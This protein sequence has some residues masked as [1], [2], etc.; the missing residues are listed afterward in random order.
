MSPPPS[1]PEAVPRGSKPTTVAG[2]SGAST[3]PE[4]SQSDVGESLPE[5]VVE[6]ARQYRQNFC[7]P[8]GFHLSADVYVLELER[9]WR[10]SWLFACHSAELRGTG[11][12]AVFGLGDDSVVLVRGGDG[13]ARAFHNVCRHRGSRLVDAPRDAASPITS[14]PP[15]GAGPQAPAR[16]TARQRPASR[17][18]CPYHQWSYQLD[19]TL[20]GCGGMDRVEDLDPSQFGLWPVQCMEVE[21][22]VFIRLAPPAAHLQTRPSGSAVAGLGVDPARPLDLARELADALAS[23]G[24][25]RAKVAHQERYEVGAGW[26][27]VWENN[28]ECWHCH[29][30][31][32]EYN[33]SH[34]DIADTSLSAV[35]HEIAE[36]TRAMVAALDVVGCSHGRGGGEVFADGGL[37]PFPSPERSWSAHRTPLARGYLTESAD[38]GALAPL[39]GAYRSHDVG[40]LRLRAL[41]NFWCHASADYAVTT[42]LA[43]ID[44]GRTEVLVTWLVNEEAEEGKDYELERLLAVWARTSEQDWA[45]CQRAQLGLRSSAYVPGPLSSRYEA[46]VSAFH[47]WYLRALGLMDGPGG[48]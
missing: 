17:L 23:Q 7:L 6:L 14:S 18:T 30:G 39:M 43:P 25:D 33:R 3:G 4:G 2:G 28:R 31:H 41:P 26:K 12:R 5:A 45:L 27:I 9:I 29:C 16:H 22:L 47:G 48:R 40:V 15:P 13:I 38:G 11:A 32:P 44:A 37:A 8:A 20:A 19:G 1:T 24:L 21:G 10:D 36:R 34:F 42:R 46:N 35:R